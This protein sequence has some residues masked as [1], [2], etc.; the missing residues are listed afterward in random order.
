MTKLSVEKSIVINAP[1]SRVWTVL[2]T[3]KF[4]QQW[5]GFFGATGPIDTDWKL[6][7]AIRWKNANDEVYVSGR[8]VGLENDKL[9]R[10]TVRA[11]NPEMQPMSG[12]AEDDITQTYAL[13]EQNGR[14]TLS[15]THGDFSKLKN[16]AQILPGAAAVWDGVLPKIKEL[17]EKL[18]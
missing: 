14:T 12:L 1:A 4:T 17:A 18:D 10:F 3:P 8:V 16:G 5:S 9:L 6:G 15:T 13:T 11:S 7:N 2:T